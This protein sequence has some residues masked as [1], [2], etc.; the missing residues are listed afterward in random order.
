MPDEMSGGALERLDELEAPATKKKK[1]W[2]DMSKP[3][4]VP[5]AP[6]QVAPQG[7]GLAG[8][9]AKAISNRKKM[10]DEL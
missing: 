4:P 6:V 3:K 8:R 7:D 2:W 10:L 9:A 5:A 1:R